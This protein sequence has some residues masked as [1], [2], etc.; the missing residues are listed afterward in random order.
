MKIVMVHGQNHEGSTCMVA[1]KLAQK[2]KAGV[3]GECTVQENSFPLLVWHTIILPQWNRIMAI[4][5]K[6]RGM[7]RSVRGGMGNE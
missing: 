2:V 4:G 5:R 1:R 6:K 7:E 3:D